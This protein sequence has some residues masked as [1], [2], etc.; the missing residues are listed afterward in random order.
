MIFVVGDMHGDFDALQTVISHTGALVILQAG[1]F[2]Y[3]PEYSLHRLPAAGF[4]TRE[5]E[6]AQVHFCDGNHEDHPAL[7]DLVKTGKTEIAPGVHYQPRGST[8][9]LEDGR[10]V[11]FAGGAE[12]VDKKLRIEGRSWFP[13]ELLEKGEVHGFPD[14]A[15]DI[16]VSHAAP[17]CISLP[18][19]LAY[20]KYTDPSR[21]ALEMLLCKY[22]PQ[23]WFFGHYHEF[24]TASHN[25]CSFFGLSRIDGEPEIPCG[26]GLV[27][28]TSTG[29]E[30]VALHLATLYDKE[31]LFPTGETSSIRSFDDGVSYV[32]EDEIPEPY[33]TEYLAGARG[34]TICR[35]EDG[36]NGIYP[37]D[38]RRYLR[39]RAK[40]N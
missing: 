28:L 23:L 24:F 17:T 2:G 13:G 22:R 16:I 9:R 3:W 29:T 7:R 19:T 6:L 35:T 25:G 36:V 34:T 20:G 1:D 12:S 8:L 38:L 26:K 5:G 4:R 30:P 37:A 21:E 31:I 14:V 11:L 40:G 27:K 10:T 39:K 33:R 32:R 15:V 18:D